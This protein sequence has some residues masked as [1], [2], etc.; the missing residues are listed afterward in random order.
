MK[1]LFLTFI[2]AMAVTVFANA[3]LMQLNGFNN[4]LWT[5]FG[6]AWNSAD[7]NDGKSNVGF[8]KLELS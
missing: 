3:Q 7:K 1:K 8:Q 6:N 2:M 4:T 5:G